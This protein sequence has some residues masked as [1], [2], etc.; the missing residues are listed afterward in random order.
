MDLHRLSPGR[1][2]LASA[3][4]GYLESER[5]AKDA[6]AAHNLQKAEVANAEAALEKFSDL[7]SQS[8]RLTAA[9]AKARVKGNWHDGLADDGSNQNWS[10]AERNLQ[11]Q[12]T[13]RRKAEL[14]VADDR[15]ALAQLEQERDEALRDLAL[16]AVKRTDA[17]EVVLAEEASVLLIQAQEAEAHAA[18][19]RAQLMAI[20]GLHISI[21]GMTKPRLLLANRAIPGNQ[22]IVSYLQSPLPEAAPSHEQRSQW[23]ALL[24]QLETNA[25]AAIGDEAV[26][27][28]AAAMPRPLTAAQALM[29]RLPVRWEE[30]TEAGAQAAQAAQVGP[31]SPHPVGVAPSTPPNDPK[32][33]DT[34][35]YR[36]PRAKPQGE[37]LTPPQVPYEQTEAYRVERSQFGGRTE[38][39]VQPKL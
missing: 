36:G 31:L 26:Q 21:A 5:A 10:K 34:S 8:A 15:A 17:I 38:P 19:L 2:Q 13:A 29:K 33:E 12:R 23:R 35:A 14:H 16:A 27:S 3:I 32:F 1:V 22:K 11:T 30:S 39:V 9:R 28:A 7:D 18:T 20:D 25:E 4:T 24:T 6:V 37:P